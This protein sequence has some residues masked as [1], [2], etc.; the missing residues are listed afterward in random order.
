MTQ[1]RAPM[2]VVHVIH[3]LGAG[4]AESVLVELARTAPDAGLRIVV[5]GLSDAEDDRAAHRLAEAGATVYQLHAAR[6]DLGAVRRVAAIARREGADVIHTHLKHADLVGGLAARLVGVP[7]VST[8]HVIEADPQGAAHR[9]RVRT[10][11]AA[12]A[13]M[14]DRVVALS[15]AQREWYSAFRSSTPVVLVPNGVREPSPSG[16][17]SAVRRELG[18]DDDTVLGVTVSLMRPEKGHAVA[19][20]AVRL[21]PAE[22]PFVLALAGD[23]PL[24]D[25]VRAEVEGD[26]LLRDRVRVLGFRSDVDD[27]LHAADLV[28]HP[29]HEDALPTSLISALATSTAVVATRVGGIPD[30]VGDDAGLLVPAGDPAA[31]NDA[32]TALTR[33]PGRREACGRAGRA[34]YDTTFAATVWVDR[35][36]SLYA[37]IVTP[38]TESLHDGPVTSVAV[39][40]AVAP[41]PPDS[42]KAMVIAGF[43]RHLR[44]RLPA[45]DIHYLHVG[46]PLRRTAEFEGVQVHEMGRPSRTD[47][48]VGLVRGV[49]LRRQ[50]LQEA[51][52][53]SPRV[54]ATVQQTL[55]DLD[56]DLE[57]IDTVRME[58][59]VAGRRFRGRRVLY[60]DDL[61]SVRYT[62]M[63]EVL[64]D[65]RIDTDFDPLG[66]FSHNV[67]SRLH[68]LT[69]APLT[70]E[71]LLRF[72]RGRV[73][74]SERRAAR[75]NPTSVLL[76]AE[77]ARHLRA[78]TG[79]AVVAVPPSI[80]G[81]DETSHQPDRWD[82]RPEFA[83]VGLLS[84]AHNHDGLGWFLREGMDELLALQPDARLHV[85]GRD[86]D[87]SLLADAARHGDRVVAH[88]F[89]PDL[90]EALSRMCALVNPLR[91]GSGI[92]IKTLD[93]LAR[94][95][96][97]VSTPVAAEGI[98]TQSRPGLTVVPDAVEAARALAALVDPA[99]R[100]RE[101][102]GA[103]ALYAERYADPVV[104]AAYDEVFGT[105]RED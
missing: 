36:R 54:A 35:L 37:Q 100:S 79:A 12:R 94:G 71:A 16:T 1:A 7:A 88:G 89:V 30:I 62:R 5:V 101:A 104:A 56:P 47:Q 98:A 64:R 25:E 70:R 15:E 18:V 73:A 40:S 76:N 34:R 17:G 48:L 61:F 85:I 3:S 33:D 68:W 102:Q 60:L 80:P 87:E 29:S 99:V 58:Q 4:G 93:G 63:L 84:L 27:L 92:K 32:I 43:L 23:G 8:L 74:R 19:L 86:A 44:S 38:P 52:L 14:F 9:A 10:A 42:G 55:V 13:T 82:G 26:P 21:L 83:F 28:V 2:T 105:A 24:L 77:E 91:F 67:P 53:G 59:H 11:V 66:Q 97:V 96:P 78:E 31:L 39:V 50:S 49:L 22:L 75:A 46:A 90:D 69:R 57:I 81:L 72:E 6:Y 95:L 41:Y 51:F 45:E 103:H 20:D 65:K